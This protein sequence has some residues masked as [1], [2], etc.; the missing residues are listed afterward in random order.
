MDKVHDSVKLREAMFC[1]LSLYVSVKLIVPDLKKMH[2]TVVDLDNM[3]STMLI[4][5]GELDIKAI[6]E[7]A[8]SYQNQEYIDENDNCM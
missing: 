2:K 8:A 3:A 6:E 7:P 5:R 1:A 4:A